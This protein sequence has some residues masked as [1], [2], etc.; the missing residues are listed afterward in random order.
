VFN[1]L[2]EITTVVCGESYHLEHVARWGAVIV[3]E[4][5]DSLADSRGAAWGA[6]RA[7]SEAAVDRDIVRETAF[8]AVKAAGGMCRKLLSHCK[9]RFFFDSY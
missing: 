5:C 3:Q 7:E 6:Y 8:P 1:A 4:I 2:V 9:I